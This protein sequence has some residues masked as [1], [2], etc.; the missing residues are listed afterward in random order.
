M[1]VGKKKKFR[2][3]A[4]SIIYEGILIFDRIFW[5][6][7]IEGF[8]IRGS[9]KTSKDVPVDVKQVNKYTIKQVKM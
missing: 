6:Y 7:F 8:Y 5:V 4:E 3:L 1:D 2:C 9:D